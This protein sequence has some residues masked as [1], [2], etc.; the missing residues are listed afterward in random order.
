M[1]VAATANVIV[2]TLNGIVGQDLPQ[3]ATTIREVN[4]DHTI[5]KEQSLVTSQ[6]LSI[7]DLIEV[8]IGADLVLGLKG[9]ADFS[10]YVENEGC[11][12]P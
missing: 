3:A 9:E 1:H 5:A 4:L 12:T 10:R 8:L 7:K 11:H 2:Q 6:F